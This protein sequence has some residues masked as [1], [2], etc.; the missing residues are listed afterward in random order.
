MEILMV[1]LMVDTTAVQTA[2]SKV[3]LMVVWMEKQWVEK[4]V[5]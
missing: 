3:P 4:K 5:E 2:V 1:A